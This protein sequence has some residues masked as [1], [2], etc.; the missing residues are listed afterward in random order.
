MASSA[1]QFYNSFYF[2]N[3]FFK[4]SLDEKAIHADISKGGEEERSWVSPA[5]QGL[6]LPPDTRYHTSSASSRNL[7]ES[8]APGSPGHLW[9]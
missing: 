3:R 5:V 2:K 1:S 8:W 4:S 9:A 6:G 7:M